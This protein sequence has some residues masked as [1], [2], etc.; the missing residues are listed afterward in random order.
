MWVPLL[1]VEVLVALL[2]AAPVAPADLGDDWRLS[3]S[4]MNIS[5]LW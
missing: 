1:V 5:W 3:R 2:V 4:S